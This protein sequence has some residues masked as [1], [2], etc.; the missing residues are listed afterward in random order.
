[1]KEKEY[2]SKAGLKGRGW[3]EAMVSRFLPEC[4]REVRNPHYACSGKMKLYSISRVQDIEAS[5][6]FSNAVGEA[7]RRRERMIQAKKEKRQAFQNFCSNSDLGIPLMGRDDVLDAAL[8]TYN[9]L[10]D[11]LLTVFGH[12]GTPEGYKPLTRDADPVFLAS[13]SWSYLRSQAKDFRSRIIKNYGTKMVDEALAII[14]SRISLKI[15]MLHPWIKETVQHQD[16]YLFIDTETTG[17]DVRYHHLVQVAWILTDEKDTPITSG[18]FII[19]PQGF[20]IPVSASRIHGI[21]N[22]KAIAE[23]RPLKEVLRLLSYSFD[24]AT[25]IV[26]HN[27]DFDL[28]FLYDA[29]KRSGIVLRKDHYVYDTADYG[30]WYCQLPSS[31]EYYE[32]RTPSLTVLYQ[33][34]FGHAF[35]GAHNAMADAQAAR[36]CYWELLRKNVIIRK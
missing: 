1:M 35:D 5:E 2:I 16:R 8:A 33:Q 19:Q 15:D 12:G 21:T 27:P 13:L 18:N 29:A 30:T 34:L 20:D 23:G 25:T 26:G 17:L 6:E 24:A 31:S 4:D 22:R 32:Y 10:M 28:G 14:G 36:R 11:D 9:G 3:T 7:N